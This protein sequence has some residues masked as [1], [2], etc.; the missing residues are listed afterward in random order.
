MR[1][2]VGGKMTYEFLQPTPIIATLNVHASRFSDL[3][4]PDYLITSPAVPVQGYRDSFREL[5]QPH[6][7]PAGRFT[8]RTDTIVRDPGGGDPA[9]FD[10]RE[11]AIEELPSDTVLF[12]LGSRYC[13]TDRLSSIAWDLFGHLPPGWERVQ[14]ICDYVHDRITFGYEHAR[15]TRTAF[16]AFE[17]QRGVCRDY[18]HLR[19]RSAGVSTSRHATATAMS[20]TSVCRC[21]MRPAILLPGWRFFSAGAGTRLIRATTAHASVGF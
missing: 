16:D 20:A 7:C 14:A 13:E 9:A 5:V 1:I 12:L 19:L 11:T 6:G 4:R 18:A 21:P 15:A 8:L 3:E 2:L 17:E 10:A